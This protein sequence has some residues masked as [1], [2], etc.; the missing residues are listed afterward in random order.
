MA[1][2]A[3]RPDYCP[4]HAATKYADDIVDQSENISRLETISEMLLTGANALHVQD[5]LIREAD[6]IFD[7]FPEAFDHWAFNLHP[8]EMLNTFDLKSGKAVQ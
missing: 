3:T 5:A 7:A 4:M 6:S 8:E 1:Y 2:D